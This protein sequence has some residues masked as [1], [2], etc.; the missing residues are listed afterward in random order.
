MNKMK[1]KIFNQ[2]EKLYGHISAASS[3]ENCNQ[4]GN[5]SEEHLATR[6]YLFCFYLNRGG[7]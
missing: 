5:I 7:R 1:L 4:T 2:N 6:F 3:I